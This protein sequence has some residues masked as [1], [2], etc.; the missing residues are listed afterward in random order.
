M[1]LLLILTLLFVLTHALI[2]LLCL[3]HLHLVVGVGTIHYLHLPW[4]R[5]PVEVRVGVEVG[6]THGQLL[7]LIPSL[8]EV[9]ELGEVGVELEAD[10]PVRDLGY[11]MVMGVCKHHLGKGY[12]L[13]FDNYFS[14]VNLAV[15]LLQNGTTCV[16]TTRPD[17]TGFPHG[18]VNKDCVV[19]SSRGMTHSTALDN[20]VPCFVWFSP[21]FLLTQS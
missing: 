9:G 20:K 14:S 3:S 11:K 6:T 19:E 16:A 10:G 21:F 17:R 8:V 12:H 1:V 18:E 7:H 4:I 15:A 13:Y 2:H 5:C